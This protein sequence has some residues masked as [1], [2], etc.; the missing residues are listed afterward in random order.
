M[1]NKKSIVVLLV[2]LILLTILFAIY[3]CLTN[4]AAKK[5]NEFL[6]AFSEFEID[7]EELTTGKYYNFSNHKN[8]ITDTAISEGI[9]FK[10]A[11]GDIQVI[12]N[13]KIN[14]MYCALENGEFKCSI[15]NKKDTNIQNIPEYDEYEI[16][17]AVALNNDLKC[18]VVNSSSK[19]SRYVTVILDERVDINQDGFTMDTNSDEDPDRIPF[20]TTGSKKYDINSK[21]NIGYYIENTFKK[22]LTSFSTILDIRLLSTDEYEKVTEILNIESLSDQ[23]IDAMWETEDEILNSIKWMEQS[24][25]P[26]GKLKTIKITD[27]QYKN[28]MPSWLYNSFS[29]NFWVIDSENGEPTTIVWNGA[30]YASVDS[31]VGY[32][33]KPVITLSKD[34]IKK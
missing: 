1:K 20:D 13:I 24:P 12:S 29:G 31:N 5:A 32:S 26:Y 25:R 4:I 15:F 17:E 19:Y 2:I 21:T 16:G 33:L 3:I 9:V 8:T 7:S 10:D 18:H 22:S 11:D 23:Q 30:G 27:K 6:K 14:G 28:L 34:N